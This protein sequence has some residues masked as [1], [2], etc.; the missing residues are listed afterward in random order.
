MWLWALW[1]F[2]TSPLLKNIVISWGFWDYEDLYFTETDAELLAKNNVW[3]MHA[4]HIPL[5]CCCCFYFPFGFRCC[6]LSFLY[7]FVWNFLLLSYL[8]LIVVIIADFATTSIAV[9]DIISL[10]ITFCFVV[11][12]VATVILLLL[13]FLLYI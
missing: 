5:D 11:L 2:D 3:S 8:A 7:M 9:Y 13:K 10:N 4:Q 6:F 1:L 12:A